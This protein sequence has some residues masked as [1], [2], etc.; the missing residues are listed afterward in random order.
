[1]RI[2]LFDCFSGIS[3]DMFLG[4]LIDAGL[5]PAALQAELDKLGI[6]GLS[7]TAE[8]T[9]RQHLAATFASVRLHDRPVPAS[10]EHHLALGDAGPSQPQGQAPPGAAEPGVSSAAA[11]E[12]SRRDLDQADGWHSHG[13]GDGPHHHH[14]PVDRPHSHGS[15]DG[16]HH[17][18]GPV[19]DP[20]HHEHADGP[21]AHDRGDGPHSHGAAD[22]PHHHDHADS[23]HAHDRGDGPHHHHGPVDDPHHHDHA[24]G[25]H[26]HD[27]GDG[28]HHH[29]GA[30]D[31]LHH[32]N[33]ADSPQAHGSG[34]GPHH[35]GGSGR[36][37]HHRLQDHL[38]RIQSSTLDEW[39]RQTACR[40]FERLARAEAQVHGVPADQVRLHEVGS[41]DALADVVGAVAG[42]RLLGVER[43]YSSPLRLGS[44]YVDCAHGRY[45]VPVPGVVAL[46]Q[47]VPCEQ[48]DIQGELVTPTGAALIT[49]LAASFEPPPPFV[50]THVG[51]GAGRRDRPRV[52][53]VLRVRLGNT[54]APT[55]HERL[56]MIEA[57][58]DDMNPE[59]YGYL[60]ELLLAQGARDVFVTPVVMKKSR[61]GAV[62]SVLADPD[63]QDLLAGLVLRETT[64]LGLRMHPVERRTLERRI[65]VA[66][67]EWGD[68]RVKVGQLDGAERYAPEYEDCAR[69]ARQ[70]GVPLLSV[71]AAALAALPGKDC[72]G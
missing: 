35:R 20:H 26:A 43:V 61:P 10:E 32:H 3:G 14:G 51:Y 22:D 72:H 11:A 41:L 68:V 12:G 55:A 57:N 58:I 7:L 52:P 37:S 36:H 23:P 33:H 40:V 24:D 15:G 49:T 13:S 19:D 67:T 54:L 30:A 71:Y 18:H 65:A 8:R 29:H 59:V 63:R 64:T 66:K 16:P 9:S 4:A 46:C 47:G 39:T 6:P 2:A 38:E 50:Q 21:H 25:P 34:D 44:G 27:R 48:T 53:N 31:D 17:H 62:L 42:L 45:P 70:H 69:L 5:D 60:F 1:M 28:P 56:V